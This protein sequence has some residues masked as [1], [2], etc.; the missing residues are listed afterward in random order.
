MRHGAASSI[1]SPHDRQS[2]GALVQGPNKTHPVIAPSNYAPSQTFASPSHMEMYSTGVPTCAEESELQEIVGRMTSSFP[3][4]VGSGVYDVELYRVVIKLAQLL[5]IKFILIHLKHFMQKWVWYE[6]FV[7]TGR[8][9]IL[10][11]STLECFHLACTPSLSS[12][13]SGFWTFGTFLSVSVLVIHS[14]DKSVQ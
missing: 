3:L 9:M 11:S 4:D 8:C 7:S 13:T 1:F 10:I 2:S 14:L 12:K 6:S 5:L